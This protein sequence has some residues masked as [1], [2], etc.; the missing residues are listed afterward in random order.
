MPGLYY[1]PV[2]RRDFLKSSFLAATAVVIPGCATAHRSASEGEVHLALLSDTHIPG[3]HAKDSR[4]GYDPCENLKAI[5]ADLVTKSP[6]GVIINGDAAFR[7]GLKP[8]YLEL[9]NLLEPASRVAPI[10]VGFGNHDDRA[11]FKQVFTSPYNNDAKVPNHQVLVLEESAVRFIVLDSLLYVN[12]VAGLLGQ[13]QRTWLTE[14]LEAHTDKPV[15]LFVHHT[16]GEGDGDLLDSNRL[17]EIIRPHRQ[18]KA[19]F[20]GHSHR[21]TITERENV[22]LI[23]LPA[24]GYNF[25]D[26]EP[27]GWV[28]ARFRRGGVDLTLH[29]ITGNQADN[30]KTTRISWS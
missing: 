26:T 27:V 24:V 14:H 4:R 29:A 6:S 5:V 28:D 15:V 16:L 12:K 23:N 25:S 22:K 21:W 11:N 10:Y 13:E 17:F 7:E 20:Y 19:I 3:D 8:D 18:V 30:G 2:H 1:Q 9:K